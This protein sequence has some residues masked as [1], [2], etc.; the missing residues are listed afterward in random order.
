M[1]KFFL[2]TVLLLTVLAFAACGSAPADVA[3]T[4]VADPGDAPGAPEAPEADAPDTPEADTPD[5]PEADTPVAAATNSVITLASTNASG[6]EAVPIAFDAYSQFAAM[7]TPQAGLSSGYD[8]DFI[9]VM[10]MNMIMD[11]VYIMA[12]VGETVGNMRAN[13]DGNLMQTATRMVTAM[14]MDMGDFVEVTEVVMDM[15]MEMDDGYITFFHVM[16]DNELFDDPMMAELFESSLPDMNILEFEMNAILSAEIEEV[17][18]EVIIDIVLDASMISELLDDLLDGMLDDMLA[19]LGMDMGMDMDIRLVAYTIV[20][21]SDGNLLRM[22]MDMDMDMGM[23]L[24]IEGEAFMF[25]VEVA[26]TTV[27]NYN[28]VGS[29]EINMPGR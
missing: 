10:E 22:Y 18:N 26:S 13:I 28:H 4:H 19:S 7:F 24:E 21:D 27:F 5:T 29:V 15:Y 25:E 23:E 20:L 11:G 14:E 3:P 9:M 6:A 8:A 1:K 12:T 2:L 17:G 16:V